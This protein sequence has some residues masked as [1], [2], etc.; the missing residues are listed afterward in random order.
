MDDTYRAKTGLKS[1]KLDNK[2]SKVGRLHSSTLLLLAGLGLIFLFGG[3]AMVGPDFVK[4]EAAVEK[5]WSETGDPR[6]QTD[7]V[8]VSQW[9]MAFSDPVL[10]TLIDKAY[11]QNLTLQIAGIRILEARARLGIA[12]GGLYP[13]SKPELVIL[14]EVNPVKTRLL[15]LP[16][17]LLS[18]I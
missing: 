15:L 18:A 10:D 13:S 3:C 2:G 12:V 7:K 5:E 14:L 16:Q 17:L 11:Q 4:P 9:W 8:D 1:K 6:V